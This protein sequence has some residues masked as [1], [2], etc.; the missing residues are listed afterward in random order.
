MREASERQSASADP[1]RPRAIVQKTKALYSRLNLR[2]LRIP[3]PHQK[4]YAFEHVQDR[5][6]ASPEINRQEQVGLAGGKGAA[7][8]NPRIAK[9]DRR[10][11]DPGWI[12]RAG[13]TR[14]EKRHVHPKFASRVEE[15]GNLTRGPPEAAHPAHLLAEEL[16]GDDTQIHGNE[17]LVGRSHAAASSR[18]RSDSSAASVSPHAAV[19]MWSRSTSRC[20]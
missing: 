17:A 20:E 12:S 7:T 13:W 3:H 1:L 4:G 5:A 19:P 15:R 10:V 6:I 18:N 8:R 16:V 9:H 14:R 2:R 11:V